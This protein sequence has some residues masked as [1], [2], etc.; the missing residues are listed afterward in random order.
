MDI[1]EF[2]SM[3]V[4]PQIVAMNEYVERM[5]LGVSFYG[6]ADKCLLIR[7]VPELGLGPE[8]D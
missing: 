8:S 6:K 3:P 2:K 7:V 1:L 5:I 4:D